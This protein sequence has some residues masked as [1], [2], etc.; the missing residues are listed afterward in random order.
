[1]KED[2]EGGLVV[3]ITGLSGAGKTTLATDAAKRLATEGWL[4]EILDGEAIRA[5]LA[6]EAGYHRAD[7]EA[8]IRQIWTLAKSKAE[9]GATV[10]VAALSPY[11]PLRREMRAEFSGYREIFASASVAEC[12]RRDPK[13]LYRQAR[14]G[15]IENFVGVHEAY[16]G[17]STDD[18]EIRT[19]EDTLSSCVEQAVSYIRAELRRRDLV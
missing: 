6:P 2:G 4:V 11:A 13:G 10:L 3:W 8:V 7:R 19:G 18:I 12:E 17:D 5:Q 1:M 14:G 15:Q 16:E 9:G